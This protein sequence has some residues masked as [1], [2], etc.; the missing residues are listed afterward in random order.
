MIGAGDFLGL[1]V[2]FPDEDAVMA[3][4]TLCNGV[5]TP[6]IQWRSVRRDWQQYGLQMNELNDVTFARESV[7]A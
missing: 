6:Y 1:H 4:R 7:M 2:L 5:V 3:G